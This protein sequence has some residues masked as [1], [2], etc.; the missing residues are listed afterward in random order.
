MES[1]DGGGGMVMKTETPDAA[2]K[3]GQFFVDQ[4]T[5]QYYFQSNDG[6]TMTMVE[7]GN[8]VD[9]EAAPPQPKP[10]TSA[11]KDNQVMLNAG[12]NSDAY[13]TVTI[14]PSDGNTGEVWTSKT[15]LVILA[16]Q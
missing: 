10:S 1:V 7:D 4:T 16:I 11:K 15:V 6:E 3:N 8:A 14:V 2:G 12:G 5:G 13:Q 9:S